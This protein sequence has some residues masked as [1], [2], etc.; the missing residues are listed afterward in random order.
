MIR[1]LSFLLFFCSCSLALMAQRETD[2]WYFGQNAS[3]EF[4]Q[5]GRPISF[6]NSAMN[7]LAGCASISDKQGNLLFYTNGVTVWNRLHQ[8]MQNGSGLAGNANALQS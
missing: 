6:N 7:T 5:S 3:I 8:V 4:N 2:N 1:F